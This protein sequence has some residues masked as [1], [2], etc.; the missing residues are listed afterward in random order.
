M[1]QL[2]TII[3]FF[4]PTLLIS[5]NQ[6]LRYDPGFWQTRYY[7]GEQETTKNGMIDYT[8]PRNVE[9]Y[10]IFR[11]AK[12]QE[13]Q[14][15]GWLVVGVAGSVMYITQQ[16]KTDK[17]LTVYGIGLGAGSVGLSMSLIMGIVAG[18]NFKKGVDVFNK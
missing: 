17:N 2:L 16:A 11:K 9:A 3:L 1:K 4:I 15:W 5:Q 6:K 8:K 14:A 18:E 7:I 10:K 13:G 12:R